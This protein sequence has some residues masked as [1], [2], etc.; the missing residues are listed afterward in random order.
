MMGIVMDRHRGSHVNM[1]VEIEIMHLQ[2]KES[3]GLTEPLE[4]GRQARTKFF[5]RASGRDQPHQP[6]GIRLMAFKSA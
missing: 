2:A 1:E 4:A 3:Q 6:L 5:L